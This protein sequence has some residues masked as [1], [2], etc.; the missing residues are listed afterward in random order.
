[1]PDSHTDE[2]LRLLASRHNV[3]IS[4]PPGTGKSR[5][6]GEVAA[7]FE[8]AVVAR[9]GP[10]VVPGAKVAIPASPPAPPPPGWYPSA[11][12]TNRKVFTTVFHQ[13]TKHRDFVSGLV[14]CVTAAGSSLTF[15][16]QIGK[17]IEA[18]EHALKPDGASLL[19]IDEINRGPAVQIFGGALVSM[20][21]DKRLDETGK[22]SKTTQTFDMAHRD[23]SHMPFALPHHLYILAAMNQADTSVEALDVAFLRRWTPFYLP[24]EVEVLHQH[25]GLPHP[26]PALPG[27]PSTGLDAYAAAV[28]AWT[29]V[30]TR[31]RIGKGS[32]Y[33]IGHGVLMGAA[34]P[35]GVA[36]ALAYIKPG[37]EVVRAHVEEV[38]FGDLRSIAA[39]LNVGGAP[40]HPLT[41]LTHT[42]ADQPRLE[43]Q[44]ASVHGGLDLYRLLASVAA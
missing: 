8:H 15:Q 6:L 9:S 18:A 20:E 13:N 26:L 35:S 3:L 1:M 38:F 19:I 25:F 39:A 11:G 23:G 32:E 12:R 5:L 17:L 37:W 4:G 16:V 22:P 2:V 33:Q 30:N 40:G 34:P 27:S 42:F 36:E 21:S 41:L 24:A 44:G 43:L 7:A 28:A 31:I 10:V 29:A 14:P